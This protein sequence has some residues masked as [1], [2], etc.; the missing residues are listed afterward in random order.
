[1]ADNEQGC[2]QWRFKDYIFTCIRILYQGNDSYLIRYPPLLT[3]DVVGRHFCAS[4]MALFIF[5]SEFSSI[6][7][8]IEMITALLSTTNVV[9]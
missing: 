2:R 9:G 5:I 4:S 3:S 1:M 7:P 6:P 8:K